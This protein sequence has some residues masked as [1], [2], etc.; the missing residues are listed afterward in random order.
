MT[1]KILLL[2]LVLASTTGAALWTQTS[3]YNT[4]RRS[5]TII[6]VEDAKNAGPYFRQGVPPEFQNSLFW[7]DIKT[8]SISA[9]DPSLEGIGQYLSNAGVGNQIMALWWNRQPDGRFNLKTVAER[10]RYNAGD[11]DKQLIGN[12]PRGIAELED[13]GLKLIAE[14]YV[15]VVTTAFGRKAIPVIKI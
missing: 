7:N 8:Q 13:A 14:T 10:G 5:F 9:P 15:L 12:G 1:K 3:G 2:I 11:L 4:Q 6:Y